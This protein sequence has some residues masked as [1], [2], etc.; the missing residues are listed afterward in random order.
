MAQEKKIEEDAPANSVAAGG[1]AGIQPGE[2]VVHKK[3]KQRDEDHV[4]GSLSHEAQKIQRQNPEQDAE[5]DAI[6]KSESS[7][8]RILRFKDF[9]NN[10]A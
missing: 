2:T 7:G 3:K 9:L 5:G 8:R 1:V 4:P 6:V 10:K